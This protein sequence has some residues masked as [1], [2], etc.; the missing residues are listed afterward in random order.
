MIG[1]RHPKNIKRIK[2]W[3]EANMNKSWV[4]GL[5]KQVKMKGENPPS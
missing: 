1:T 2:R 4:K 3:K 5:I